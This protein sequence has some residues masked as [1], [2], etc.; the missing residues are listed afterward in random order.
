[1]PSVSAVYFNRMVLP[2]LLQAKVSRPISGG[3]FVVFVRFG[4]AATV[5]ELT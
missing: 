2:D 4:C 3:V 5:E 1:L